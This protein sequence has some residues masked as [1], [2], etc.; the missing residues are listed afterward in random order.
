MTTAEELWSVLRSWRA[1]LGA[2]I[3]CVLAG[4]ALELAPPLIVQ[5]LID[6]HL[7]PGDASGIAGLA[8]LYLAATAAGKGVGFASSYLITMAAQDGLHGLRVRLLG[9][10]QR[11]PLGFYDTTPTGDIISRA[12]ADVEA[13]DTLF[14][15]GV[16]GLA[17]ELVRLLAIGAALIALSP[18]LAGLSALALPPLLAVTRRFQRRV[19]DAESQHRVAVGTANGQLQE[20]LSGAEVIHAF[21]R[22]AHFAGRFGDALVRVLLAFDRTAA[23]SSAYSPIMG[24][25]AA[26]ASA[27][28]LVAFA[29]GRLGSAVSVGTLT[30]FV[31]LFQRFFKPLI[32]V[33]DE[34]QSVQTAIAG[35]ERIFEVLR[36]PEER[37][38]PTVSAATA[39]KAGAAIAMTAVR[40]GYTPDRAIL[41]G[42]SLEVRRGE[43]VAIVGR[44]GA[45]KSST[46]HLLAGLYAPWAGT[47]QVAGVDP[48]AVAPAARRHLIGVVP[49]AVQ[50]FGETI[51]ENLTLGDVD[52]PR[53]AVERACAVV[54]AE[55]FIRA[56]PDGLDTVLRGVGGGHGVELSAGQQQLL[57]LARALVFE[58]EVLLFDE[59]TAAI[60][61]ATDAKLRAALRAS[62][63]PR[64]C[65]VLT[66]A[67]RLSTSRDADRVIVLER[68]AI[69]EEGAPDR[70]A[71][72]GGR[73]ATWLELEAAGW[74]LG[75]S[76]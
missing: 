74:D 3:L 71:R 25:L 61:S 73:F 47:I 29:S 13:V 38:R 64:G 53:T 51:L 33:G 45:G 63:L 70:L 26:T 42:L 19:R 12:T 50:L 56:L 15:S 5:R 21:R 68:G 58:P 27:G 16:A 69:V 32:A 57:S 17:T 4:A 8:L 9:H 72:A 2:A 55:T 24:V 7:V 36:L 23:Y 49:Q 39:P 65:S 44:T 11:L 66:I 46:L 52:V 34:W 43:H 18:V 14:S 54:G 76:R 40:F 30:A 41:H 22:Q 67:H 20:I 75:A 31:L 60:D 6:R 1:A 59:A 10:L 35:A 48:C 28:L 37:A 62:V